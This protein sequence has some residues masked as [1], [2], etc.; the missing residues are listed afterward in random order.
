MLSLRRYNC[1][2]VIW[3][4]VPRATF[5]AG[6]TVASAL[7]PAIMPICPACGEIVCPLAQGTRKRHRRMKLESD[8][9]VGGND[10]RSKVS[11]R[12]WVIP[13]AHRSANCRRAR[14]V[15][16]IPVAEAFLRDA[17]GQRHAVIQP[18]FER[19]EIECAVRRLIHLREGLELPRS[20]AT[21]R[22][23]KIAV[24]ESPSAVRPMRSSCGT[25]ASAMAEM[26]RAPMASAAWKSQGVAKRARPDTAF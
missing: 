12:R 19:H 6:A 17:C 21:D 15:V 13:A 25:K 5:R 22:A 23:C 8:T 20:R 14:H 3:R 9:V 26:A 11:T 16:A 4:I 2:R 18:V 24:G 7:R 1:H 10:G